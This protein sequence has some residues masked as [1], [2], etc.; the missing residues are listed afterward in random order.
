MTH[1]T[2]NNTSGGN[3]VPPSF[4]GLIRTGKAHGLVGQLIADWNRVAGQ[5]RAVQR[6]NS[7]GLPGEP[8][9]HLNEMV[10]RAGF[11]APATCDV[12]DQYLAALV[13]VAATDPLAAQIVIHRLL[14]PLIAIAKRR[15]KIA[16]GGIEG[17][18]TNVMTRAWMVICAYPSNRRPR[19]IA[20]NI[21]RDVEYWE[22]VAPFRRRD[23]ELQYYAPDA[24]A[25]ISAG[26]RKESR[27]G[28]CDDPAR[29]IFLDMEARGVPRIRIE[30]L[31]LVSDGLSSEEIALRLNMRP[32]TVR[33]HR[34]EAV[35]EART[36]NEDFSD[37]AVSRGVTDAAVSRG[38][39]YAAVSRGEAEDC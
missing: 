36:S 23:A 4:P 1:A 6:A 14:P 29:E 9:T 11:D 32:R 30:I 38:V 10:L 7:W 2:H 37:A 21:V 24:L 13:R 22:Y 20:S 33:W 27:E 19:K 15:G 34:I 12:S 17:A 3:A 16:P 26:L 18:L 25:E 28:V 31:R 5:H 8:V 35:R 39:T